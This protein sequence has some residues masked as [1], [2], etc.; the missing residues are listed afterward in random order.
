M[1]SLSDT[2]LIFRKWK[3]DSSWVELLSGPL[4][5]AP[6]LRPPGTRFKVVDVLEPNE[7]ALLPEGKSDHPFSVDLRGATFRYGD[8]RETYASTSGVWV[9]FIEVKL[10]S[11]QIWSLGER[12]IS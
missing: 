2:F 7:I 11:G 1:T 3:E 6:I 8:P 9:C 10:A 5:D 12:K 4:E